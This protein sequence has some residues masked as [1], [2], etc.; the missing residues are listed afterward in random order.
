[1]L[2]PFQNPLQILL[3]G[4]MHAYTYTKQKAA[5]LH[6]A[7]TKMHLQFK[8]TKQN[9]YLQSSISFSKAL[10]MKLLCLSKLQKSTIVSDQQGCHSGQST[11]ETNSSAA[12]FA[13][14]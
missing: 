7:N 4:W 1:M 10:Y 14:E 3:L 2:V 6:L 11:W 12:S 5:T 8:E 13:T 9:L